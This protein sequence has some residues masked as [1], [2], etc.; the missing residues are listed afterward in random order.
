MSGEIG[1]KNIQVLNEAQMRLYEEEGRVMPDLSEMAQ[2]DVM[3][4][5]DD[6]LD[7]VENRKKEREILPALPRPR[8][9][10]RLKS[11][12]D[13]LPPEERQRIGKELAKMARHLRPLMRPE[14]YKPLR[15]S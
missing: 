7:T 8:G 1:E 9:M 4:L 2:E 12:D 6:F 13:L 11:L 10:K 14:D 3:D 15:R 5:W